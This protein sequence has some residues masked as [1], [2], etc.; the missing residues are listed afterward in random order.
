MGDQHLI[1]LIRR[2]LKA[3]VLEEEE[4][5]PNEKGTP[6]GGSISVLLSNVYLHYYVLDLWFERVAKPRLRAGPIWCGAS[7]T[8]RC[9]SNIVRMLFVSRRHCARDWGSLA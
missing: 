7:T 6:R 5:H 3:S 2:W 4:V 8:L 9:A 1:S